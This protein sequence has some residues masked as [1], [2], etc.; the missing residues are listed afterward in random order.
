MLTIAEPA[1]VDAFPA[2][3][4]EIIKRLAARRKV[5]IQKRLQIAV[6]TPPGDT[7]GYCCDSIGKCLLTT[8][9]SYLTP[10]V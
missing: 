3:G 10:Q 6:K 8:H 2:K 4:G 9:H 5:F 7:G 1:F